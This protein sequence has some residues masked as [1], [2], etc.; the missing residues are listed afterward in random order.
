MSEASGRRKGVIFVALWS[1]VLSACAATG[2]IPTGRVGEVRGKM[3]RVEMERGLIAV[4]SD[5]DGGEQWFQLRPFTGVSGGD[6]SSVSALKLGERVY[7][8]YLQE[9]RTDP[10]E[11]LS[12]TVLRYTLKPSA[13][14]L[15]SLGIPGL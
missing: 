15:G 5:P 10:P 14:G 1:L 11:V 3:V 9:P 2:P 12:I 4:G 8:R 7:V 6:I 13:K